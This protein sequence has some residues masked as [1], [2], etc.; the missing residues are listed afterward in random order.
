MR[1]ALTRGLDLLCERGFLPPDN[2]LY[3]RK[4][5]RGEK[6][7][8]WTREEIVEFYR[9]AA[10]CQARALEYLAD[11]PNRWVSSAELAEHIE[12]GHDGNVL[13]GTMGSLAQTAGRFGKSVPFKKEW[14][15]KIAC[16]R[17]IMDGQIAQY[18]RDCPGVWT[19]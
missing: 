1:A 2:Q 16:T 11:R 9:K 12:P 3:I 7:D 8:R 18:I 15:S 13:G 17:Y 4:V 19:W 5:V 14:D 10:R 6:M